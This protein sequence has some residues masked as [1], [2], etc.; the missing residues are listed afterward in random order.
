M[1]ARLGVAL[2]EVIFAVV[3]Y[4]SV[5]AGTGIHAHALVALCAV[6]AG[7]GGALVKVL[8]AI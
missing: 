8:F 5:S 4:P 3:S 6:L 1:L 7:H 2:V